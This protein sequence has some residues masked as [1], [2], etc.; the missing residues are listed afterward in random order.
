MVAR[1]PSRLVLAGVFEPWGGGPSYGSMKKVTWMGHS[2]ESSGMVWWW[3]EKRANTAD[4]RKSGRDIGWQ[5][6]QWK[7]W[8]S[9]NPPS[10]LLLHRRHH[11]LH[12]AASRSWPWPPAASNPRDIVCLRLA[13]LSYS[14][15]TRQPPSL[16]SLRRLLGR[17]GIVDVCGRETVRGQRSR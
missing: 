15:R 6:E 5:G 4:E 10:T 11:L 7:S 13:L 17:Y 9:I 2:G 14:F 12:R 3:W 8:R 1:K 16:L